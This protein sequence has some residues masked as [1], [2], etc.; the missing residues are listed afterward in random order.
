MPNK[1]LP[2]FLLVA[3]LSPTAFAKNIERQWQTGTLVDTHQGYMGNVGSASEYRV[4]RTYVI[5]AGDYVY[6]CQEHLTKWSQASALTANGPVQFAIEK[7]D[8][9][10]KSKDNSEHE[11]ILI[12]KTLKFLAGK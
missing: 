11:T 6:E 9:Y 8:I 1:L 10:I 4:Y 7:Y 5:D 12:K 2:L 3:V